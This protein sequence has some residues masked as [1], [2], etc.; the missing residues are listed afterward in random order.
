VSDEIETPAPTRQHRAQTLPNRSL[1]VSV[2]AVVLAVLALGMAVWAL[3][4]SHDAAG[5]GS[6]TDGQRS[7]AKATACAAFA[8][9]R[10][11]VSRN[12]NIPVP[13]GPENVAGVLGVAANARISLLDGGQYLVA[14]L[15]PAT[16][17]DVADAAREFADKL[18][19]IGAA[20]T[21]GAPDGDPE[22]AARLKQADEI[23]VRLGNLCA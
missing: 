15:D 4:R 1:L 17:S 2:V 9:V 10:S 16:P 19:D 3:V 12:T 13:G 22:Q 8:T 20:A 11:G 14:R 18:M 5:P 6:Y 21:A 23:N 7:D